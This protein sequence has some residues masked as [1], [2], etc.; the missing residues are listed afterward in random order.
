MAA[1]FRVGLIGLG[2]V[3]GAVAR[4]LTEG[5]SISEAAGR[6]VVLV[7]VA[8]GRPPGR[9]APAPLVL[10]H[11]LLAAKSLAALI[12]VAGGLGPAPS[13]FG[14]GLSVRVAAVTARK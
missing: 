14:E 2:H 1:R 7:G 8:G 13:V 6:P 4:R 9:T 5:P 10:A 3:G 12:W 11:A